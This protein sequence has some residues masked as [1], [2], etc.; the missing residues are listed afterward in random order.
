[1]EIIGK[2]INNL[3]NINLKVSLDLINFVTGMLGSG[4][5][6]LIN[7]FLYKKLL[8][9]LKNSKIIKNSKN[10]KEQRTLKNLLI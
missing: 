5:S 10:L 7:E 2:N 6:F 1:M 9:L 4:K 8:N 3:K